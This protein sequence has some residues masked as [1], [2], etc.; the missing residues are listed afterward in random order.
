M[1][2]EVSAGLPKDSSEPDG[3]KRFKMHALATPVRLSVRGGAR[4]GR[5]D[6]DPDPGRGGGPTMF[7]K[8]GY[9]KPVTWKELEGTYDFNEDWYQQKALLGI[10]T[11]N[12]FTSSARAGPR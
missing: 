5:L 4:P 6:G 12:Q 3:G 10:Q 2:A 7:F 8:R 11:A 9:N 1:K